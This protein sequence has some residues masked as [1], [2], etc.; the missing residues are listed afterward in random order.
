MGRVERDY[1]SNRVAEH[2]KSR[3]L[4]G[5]WKER[6][7]G[8]RG[9]CAELGISRSTYQRA[10]EVLEDEG[11]LLSGGERKGRFIDSERIH[12]ALRASSMAMSDPPQKLTRV[13]RVVGSLPR[14][15]QSFVMR[16][17]LR[18]LFSCLREVDWEVKYHHLAGLSRRRVGRAAREL[19]ENHPEDSWLLISASLQSLEQAKK[20]GVKAWSL[21]DQV[22]ESVELPEVNLIHQE[23]LVGAA[24]YAFQRSAVSPIFLL[25]RRNEALPK[26]LLARLRSLYEKE[27]HSFDPSIHCPNFDEAKPESLKALLEQL[28]LSKKPCALIFRNMKYYASLLATL[29]G[30]GRSLPEDWLVLALQQNPLVEWLAPRPAIFDLPTRQIAEQLAAAISQRGELAETAWINEIVLNH[31]NTSSSPERSSAG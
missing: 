31:G 3:L 12:E 28:L 26:K 25:P 19:F 8:Y 2:L 27:G 15:E 17:V 10:C 4:A 30:Q 5:E 24:N 29:A 6:L 22:Q 18:E 14:G 16:E 11:F 13:L 7:P 9:L 21:T 23:L 20:A 1:L